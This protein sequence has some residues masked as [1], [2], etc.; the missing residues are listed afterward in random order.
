[1]DILVLN[2]SPRKK[3]IISQ[4]VDAFVQGIEDANEFDF[5]EEA[6]H[7]EL[8]N[9]NDLNFSPCKGCM[10]CRNHGNC[11]QAVDDAHKVAERIRNCDILVVASP[12]YWG[13][14]PGVLKCLFDRMVYA[15]MGET[16]LGIPRPMHKGK[17]AY[18]I[19][20]CTTPFPFNIICKQTSGVVGALKE[21]LGTSGF[22]IKGKVMVPGTKGKTEL[23]KRTYRAAYNLGKSVA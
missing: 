14:I 10:F 16:K 23:P 11:C 7:V 22:K 15:M 18:V 9:V 12:V 8:I 6:P 20:G 5:S 3:G 19:S 13:N 4:T 17:S 2:A 21:I 1:M